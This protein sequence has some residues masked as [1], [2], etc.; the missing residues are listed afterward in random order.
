MKLDI[1]WI[2]RAQIA[3]EN[4]LSKQLDHDDWFSTQELVMILCKS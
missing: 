2:L 4:K 3:E 1:L